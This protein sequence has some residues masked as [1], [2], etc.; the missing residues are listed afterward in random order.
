MVKQSVCDSSN[1]EPITEATCLLVIS[2]I[3]AMHASSI[4]TTDR[5]GKTDPKLSSF[6]Y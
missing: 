1:A 4:S 2:V 3:A 5:I 6:N